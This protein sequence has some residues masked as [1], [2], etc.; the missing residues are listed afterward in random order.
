VAAFADAFIGPDAWAAPTLRAY[1][2][3]IAIQ[4]NVLV[5]LFVCCWARYSSRLVAR[6]EGEQGSEEQ[7]AATE[8]WL[9]G[10]RYY[11]LWKRAVEQAEASREP[12]RTGSQE[13]MTASNEGILTECSPSR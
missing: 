12:A 8:T 13:T 5:P 1:A 6:A 7:G 9:R 2:D 11:A 4:A 10:N 3:R